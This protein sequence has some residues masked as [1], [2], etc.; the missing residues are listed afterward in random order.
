MKFK[1]RAA[2]ILTFFVLFA[3]ILFL[4]F[5]ARYGESVKKGISLWA[6][7]VLPATLPFFFLVTLFTGR[8]LFERT[9]RLL[10]PLSGKLF[11]ISGAGASAFLLSAISGYPVGARTILDLSKS[12]RLQEEEA[13]RVACLATTSGPAFLVGAVG[14]GMFQ[15]AAAGALI[16]C[17]H[18][19]GI[20]AVSFLLRFGAKKPT[21]ALP[22][23]RE[24]VPLGEAL[25][26]AV[27][28]VLFVGGAVA[29]FYAFGEMISDLAALVG[30][31]PALG[32]VV[33]GLLEMTGGCA[34]FAQTPSPLSYAACAFFVTFGGLCVLVQQSAFLAGAKVKFLPFVL[35]KFVQGVL[36]ALLAYG[37]ALLFF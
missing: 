3:L 30:A 4:A 6:V 22:P 16:Y 18:L 8:G 10:S 21:R 34:L 15:S 24:E 26:R 1:L 9:S 33:R 31:P 12:G 2:H 19:G 17:C 5:P 36:A 29:I 11:R 27:L 7:S 28:S 37:S 32:A 13:F 23:P 25:S 14:S 35:V 20:V